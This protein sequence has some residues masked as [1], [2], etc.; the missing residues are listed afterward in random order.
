MEI[1]DI[2]R[3]RISR[4]Q[5]R[6]AAV[7]DQSTMCSILMVTGFML[8]SMLDDTILPGLKKVVLF[9]NCLSGWYVRFD[10]YGCWH[11]HANLVDSFLAFLFNSWDPIWEC[12]SQDIRDIACRWQGLLS[13]ICR[14][15]IVV[16]LLVR[17]Y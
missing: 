7:S 8:T 11:W 13:I 16:T 6:D 10:A 1:G 4:R 12:L 17:A 15:S 2:L 5:R 3:I 9:E 14:R